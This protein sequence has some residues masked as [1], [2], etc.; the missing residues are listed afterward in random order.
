MRF[1]T[2]FHNTVFDV[3]KGRGWK[4]TDSDTEFDL[5][6]ADRDWTYGVMDSMHLDSW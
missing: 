1:R 2:S 5:H 4:E 6:W 3:M